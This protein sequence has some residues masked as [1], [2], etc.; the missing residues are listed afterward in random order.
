VF[1]MLLL[2]A[3]V[4]SATGADDKPVDG[5][6]FGEMRMGT[7][8]NSYAGG[9]VGTVLRQLDSGV[10]YLEFDIYAT[11]FSRIG[12][13]TLGHNLPGWGVSLGDG[14]PSS[15]KLG[16]WLGVV[17]GWSRAHVGHSPIVL[18][19]DLKEEICRQSSFSEGDPAFLNA[20]LLRIFG[21]GLFR[22]RDFSG[23]WP[24]VSDLKGKVIVL[25]S[26]GYE[27]RCEYR[28]E[29]AS[30]PVVALNDSGQVVEAHEGPDGKVWYWTGRLCAD[31]KVSWLR[32]GTLGTGVLPGVSLGEGGEV[33]ISLDAEGKRVAVDGRLDEAMEIVFSKDGR[34]AARDG[35]GVP[36]SAKASRAEADGKFV[37]VFTGRDGAA[38]EDTLC[39]RTAGVERARVRFEQ[40]VFVEHQ[41]G[42]STALLEDGAPFCATEFDPALLDWAKEMHD[43]GRMVRFWG[44]N[45]PPK[46]DERAYD[47]INFPATDDPYAEWY[48]KFC[49]P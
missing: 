5:L 15:T 3:E 25:F 33:V 18:M 32:R 44:F 1:L 45:K 46:G 16:E 2:V 42:E 19:L 13:Y 40:V 39:Y 12:D 6:R 35:E 43:K 49:N 41:H 36:D 38:P 31:G 29:R 17:A 48:R 14:N 8:H 20:Q 27:T 7:S 11:D 22:A 28:W 30:H 9:K 24:S 23:E 37:E 10:R 4:S 47:V 21:D 34:R 26:G